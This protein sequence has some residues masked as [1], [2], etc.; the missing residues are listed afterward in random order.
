MPP[1]GGRAASCLV[2]AMVTW[3]RRLKS[4]QGDGTGEEQRT[5]LRPQERQE[6]PLCPWTAPP[7]GASHGLPWTQ[8]RTARTGR[9]E[10]KDGGREGYRG[11]G[12]GR[13]N[14]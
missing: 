3:E 6:V 10:C 11:G 13:R 1:D 2:V 12:G 14:R 7:P 8:G 9:S 5:G 4:D